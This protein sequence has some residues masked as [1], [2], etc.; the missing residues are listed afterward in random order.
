[1]TVIDVNGCDGMGY[2]PGQLAGDRRSIS[3]ERQGEI[4]RDVAEY[5]AQYGP[6]PA[7]C[8]SVH[9]PDENAQGTEDT[10][11]AFA[12]PMTGG[13]RG[14]FS[15]VLLW[16]VAGSVTV[17]IRERTLEKARDDLTPAEARAL[18]AA[19]VYGAELAE[20]RLRDL[21]PR[22]FPRGVTR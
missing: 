21:A 15:G 4:G 9:E 14:D 8:E 13:Y 22:R 11:H 19:L 20:Q 5:I 18:A 3:P 16:E 6:C 7:W 12:L 2:T 1:M 17:A 10:Y